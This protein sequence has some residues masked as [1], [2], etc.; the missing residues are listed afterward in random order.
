M[1]TKTT[2]PHYSKQTEIQLGGKYYAVSSTQSRHLMDHCFRAGETL[3]F[4]LSPDR[5]H[6]SGGRCPERV[7][8]QSL[9]PE[10]ID[11]I[12]DEVVAKVSVYGVTE[13]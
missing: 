12:H 11:A 8:F 4:D 1:V 3:V 5:K 6:R 13:G 2:V 9:S 7:W 10:E